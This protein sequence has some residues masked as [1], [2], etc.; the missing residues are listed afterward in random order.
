MNPRRPGQPYE[1]VQMPVY[2]VYENFR[3]ERAVVHESTCRHCNSG[4]GRGERADPENGRWR[5]P[6]ATKEDAKALAEGTGRKTVKDCEH[7]SP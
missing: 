6:F 5:G 7:C 4:R 3:N 1:Q 2:W